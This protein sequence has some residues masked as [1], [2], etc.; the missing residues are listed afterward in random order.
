METFIDLGRYWDKDKLLKWGQLCNDCGYKTCGDLYAAMAAQMSANNGELNLR[1]STLIML[2]KALNRLRASS[3]SRSEFSGLTDSTTLFLSAVADS[4]SGIDRVMPDA[5]ITVM[6][7]LR[8]IC[9]AE[10]DCAV[11]VN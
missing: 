2:Y 6:A 4:I 9:A 5:E 1:R 7:K 3:S 10:Q 8:A 11:S